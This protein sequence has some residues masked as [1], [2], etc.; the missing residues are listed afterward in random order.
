ML[1]S[2]QNIK[3]FARISGY[4]PDS[5]KIRRIPNLAE[6]LSTFIV[7]ILEENQ[8]ISVMAKVMT[9]IRYIKST[10]LKNQIHQ[11]CHVSDII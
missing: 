1:D 3:R 7:G 5:E 11:S 2:T 10:M 8:Y 9:S 4:G 6:R